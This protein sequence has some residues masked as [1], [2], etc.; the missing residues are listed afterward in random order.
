[1][2]IYGRSDKAVVERLADKIK[3]SVPDEDLR[4]F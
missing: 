2:R 4:P 3:V 1:M